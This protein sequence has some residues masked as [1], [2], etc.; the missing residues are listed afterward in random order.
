MNKLD[1]PIQPIQIIGT[2]RS[3]SNL[4][5]VMLNELSEVAA[6]HPPHILKTF[7]PLVSEY[8]DLSDKG[9]FKLLVDDVC[10]FVECNPVEW[11][12]VRFD[13]Q[14]VL[15]S[16]LQPTL[17]EVFRVVYEKMAHSHGAKFWC[18][19]SM[20]NAHYFT[21]LENSGIKPFYIHL[22]R[23]GRDVALS[24]R[25]VA[26]GDKH[27][28]HLAKKW[29]EDQEASR[30]VIETVGPKRGIKVHYEELISNPEAVMKRI[31]DLIGVPYSDRVLG[32]FQSEESRHTAASGYM[33]HNLAQPILADNCGK[34]TKAMSHDELTLFEFVAGDELEQNGYQR[35]VEK[36][37]LQLSTKVL[38]DFNDE[39]ERLKKAIRNSNHLK[40][41]ISKRI[42]QEELIKSIKNRKHILKLIHA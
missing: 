33:W 41:D 10:R 22:L 39:N 16:C 36:R 11:D 35:A 15:S 20:V 21:D 23:D 9:N 31:C 26:V 3:G 34:Y 37:S 12:G 7:L 29:K 32:Y 19:K 8:G 17:L 14:S 40:I 24:F 28:F 38:S 18:C 25:K 27:F 2:Q 5:R 6:P 42:K 4:L 30:K 13:R 1:T